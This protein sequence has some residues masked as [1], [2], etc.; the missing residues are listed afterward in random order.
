MRQCKNT[1]DLRKKIRI[2]GETAGSRSCIWAD[3]PHMQ[4]ISTQ[5]KLGILIRDQQ[6][7]FT[8]VIKPDLAKSV[9]EVVPCIFSIKNCCSSEADLQPHSSRYVFTASNDTNT[10]TNAAATAT[11]T[12]TTDTVS[13]PVIT[14]NTTT[15]I[16]VVPPSSVTATPRN[17]DPVSVV[18]ASIGSLSFMHIVRVNSCHYN[19][20]Y[21][22]EQCLFTY[23]E[24]LETSIAN[25]FAT[26]LAR[27]A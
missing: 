22:G 25:T 2:S 26:D 7:A 21:K 23:S 10:N 11:A 5:L 27:I 20:F 16:Q 18:K 1:G 17:G 6:R 4:I 12:T 15:T 3:W 24:L 14:L 19:L 8:V 13:S 9:Q